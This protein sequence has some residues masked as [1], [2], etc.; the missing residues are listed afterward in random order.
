MTFSP[1]TIH[2]HDC[3]AALRQLPED[4]VDLAFADPPFNIGYQYDVY[5]DAQDAQSYLSWSREWLT[6]VRRVLKPNGAFWLAIGD[7][8]AAE[9]KVLSQEIGFHCRSWVI[10]YYTFGVNC[11]RK[12]NRSHVHLFHF[13]MNPKEFTFNRQSVAVPSARQLVYAD[14]RANPEGRLPDDTWILRP[15]DC[16]SGFTPNEDT[17]YFPRVAGTFKERAGFHGCQMPEQLLGRIIKV[18][19]NK[20]GLVLDPFSGSATTLAVAKKLGREYLGFEISEEYVTRGL[21]RLEAIN[22]GDPLDGAPEPLVSAPSTQEKSHQPKSHETNGK[23]ASR[24]ATLKPRRQET[25]DE[26]RVIEAFRKTY[27]GF[28]VDRVVADRDRNADFLSQC[29]QLGLAGSPAEL[30]RTLF[31]LRKAGRLVSLPTLHRTTFDWEECDPFLDASEIALSQMLASGCPTLD[32]V[33]CDPDTAAEFDRIAMKFAPG[34]TSLQYRWAALKLRKAAKTAR[35]RSESLHP[36]SLNRQPQLPIDELG[37]TIIT[38]EPGVY[39]VYS[40]QRKVLFVG[41]SLNLQRRLSRAFVKPEHAAAWRTFGSSI[42]VKFRALEKLP[43]CGSQATPQLLA[44]KSLLVSARRPALN[45]A[46]SGAI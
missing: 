5:N 18:S 40:G 38:S 27:D 1:N 36:V 15:Q 4:S 33:L 14:S 21:S 41:E 24:K 45:I 28:S 25:I 16:A 42:R 3:V 22:P 2:R 26:R 44:Y 23:N 37:S 34:H 29:E 32:E 39:F 35:I 10:W 46:T 43:Q 13:V 7:D 9:L 19:S 17:W 30:N 31:R 8:Y 6:G 12:F 20:G 11:K